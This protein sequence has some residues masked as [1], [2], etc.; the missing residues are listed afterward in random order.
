MLHGGRRISPAFLCARGVSSV[1]SAAVS[2]FPPPFLCTLCVKSFD[3]LSYGA[4]PSL[5]PKKNR[6]RHRQARGATLQIVR[7]RTRRLAMPRRLRKKR[8]RSL[9][10]LL[11]RHVFHVRCDPPLV[12]E[13]IRDPAEAIAPEL[14]FQRH[15]N[16]CAGGH[17][18]CE[19]L[20]RI[21][22]VQEQVNLRRSRSVGRARP[23]RI[24]QKYN[25]IA[26]FKFC[27][28][29]FAVRRRH[30]HLFLGAE[31][32]LVKIDRARRVFTG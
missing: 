7:P 2:D 14:V 29:D 27:V 6:A 31:H 10:N 23:H 21:F 4:D 19:Y 13:R 15:I 9:P 8:R 22:H 24:V 5:P 16:F 30:P 25:R 20:V 11:R 26:N 32:L 12:S 28:R 18:S 17:R 3:L 1:K